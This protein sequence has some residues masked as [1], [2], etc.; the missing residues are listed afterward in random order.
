MDE[1]HTEIA[2]GTVIDLARQVI[3][4]RREDGAARLMRQGRPGPPARLDGHTV[5]A[6]MI[7][8]DAPHDGERHPDG[9]ELL[10]VGSGRIEVNLELEDGDQ[11]VSSGP[12]EAVVVPRGVWHR[13]RLVEPG[14][15]VNITPGP[16]GDH[17]PL[18]T[19]G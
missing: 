12:G 1:Q 10:F 14:Q 6:G 7:T 18:P 19:V 15:L 11:N 8:G 4:L 17:R 3:G 9:D 2:P 13:I 16:R 5:G